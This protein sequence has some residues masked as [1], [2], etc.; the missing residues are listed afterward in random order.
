MSHKW[1]R[2]LALR[3]GYI[4]AA[5]TGAPPTEGDVLTEDCLRLSAD[6]LVHVCLSMVNVI[7]K[8]TAYQQSPEN[9]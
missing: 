5:V 9:D 2:L 3:D 6:L 8:G 4:N 7:C 1:N